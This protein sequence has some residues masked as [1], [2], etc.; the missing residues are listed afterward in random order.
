MVLGADQ[1]DVAIPEQRKE[2][3]RYFMW[4]YWAVNLGATISFGVLANV[5]VNGIPPYVPEKYGFFASF[6]IPCAS[7][8]VGIMIF[9]SGKKK[10]RT[11]AP[12]DDALLSVIRILHVVARVSV[13]G[14]LLLLSGYLLLPAIF[15]SSVSYFIEEGVWHS[16]FAW[17]GALMVLSIAVILVYVGKSVEW[18]RS[19]MKYSDNVFADEQVN[20]IADAMRL[21]CIMGFGT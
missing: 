19:A 8:T 18:F 17:S 1:F 21:V 4:F 2:K 11:V 7:F 10:Y 15:L 12:D 6:L 16:L 13:K 5:A 3:D 9:V 14:R 20:D